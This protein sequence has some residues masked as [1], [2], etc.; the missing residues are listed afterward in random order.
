MANP[1]FGNIGDVWKHLPLTAIL[2]RER[3][4][5][6]WESH[7]GAA[8]YALSSSPARDYGIFYFLKNVGRSPTLRASAYNRT[9]E[10][11]EEMNGSVPSYPGSPL[12]ALMLLRTSAAAFIFCDIN[13]GSLASVSDCAGWIGVNDRRIQCVEGDGVLALRAELEKTPADDI[14]DTLVFIDPFDPFDGL[15]LG[16][17]P[18]NLFCLATQAGARA[19]LWYGFSSGQERTRTWDN[20]LKTLQACGID[21]SSA[22]LW[23]G[24]ICLKLL[25]DR[26]FDLNPGVR[27]C[28][29]LTANLSETTTRAC[30]DLG[31]EL[32]RVYERSRFP[33]GQS[34]AFDFNTVSMW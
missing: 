23:C 2:A 24:E 15:D 25:D 27:G 28:G 1:H 8:K 11:I 16:I 29:M 14:I 33:G 5:R 4:G 21:S 31:N 13:A 17:S 19:V 30:A 20:I 7:C 9:L 18:M 22:V 3:P 26:E 32:S 6:Y 12:F 10:E 34:G